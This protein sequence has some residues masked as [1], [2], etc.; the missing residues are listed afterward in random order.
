[1]IRH[2]VETGFGPISVQMLTPQVIS[3]GHNMGRCNKHAQSTGKL[4]IWRRRWDHFLFYIFYRSD[5]IP[6]MACSY[7][8]LAFF[9]NQLVSSCFRWR[10]DQRWLC[11]GRQ[12]RFSVNS[13]VAMKRSCLPK[14]SSALLFILTLMH[15]IL[16]GRPHV[17]LT[18]R[19]A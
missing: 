7:P 2:K 3:I 9:F 12:S 13:S 15:L 1:M 11:A 19:V 10:I 16:T 14:E 5:K 17:Y 4:K 6:V 18:E 8:G